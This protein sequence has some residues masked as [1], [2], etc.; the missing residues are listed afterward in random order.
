MI[1]VG[2][3]TRDEYYLRIAEAVAS[4]STCIKRK[5]GCVIVNHDE[6]VATGYNGN[7]RGDWNC[8]DGCECLRPDAGHNHSD[9]GYAD[10]RSVHAEQNALISAARRDMV[11]GTMYLVAVAGNG[12]AILDIPGPCPICGRMV[13]NAGIVRLCTWTTG[14]DGSVCATV[15]EL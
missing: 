6:I 15:K 11:G 8:C 10:C 14:A 2:R 12:S 4:R 3:P 7:V 5:Y 1:E 13:R 9:S